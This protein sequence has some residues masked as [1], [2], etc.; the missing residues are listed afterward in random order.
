MRSGS[1]F[2][3]LGEGGDLGARRG[4]GRWSAASA[5][6]GLAREQERGSGGVGLGVCSGGGRLT[7]GEAVERGMDG[8][9][10]VEGVEALGAAAQ[11][12]GVSGAA[13]EQEAEDGGLARRRTVCS[14]LG[15]GSHGR[16][17]RGLRGSGGPGGLLLR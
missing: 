9:E 12:P 11:P 15:I 1:A 14:Y 8:G 13:Q 5:G 6:A 4:D 10:V 17:R 16:R 2:A 3:A 7:G